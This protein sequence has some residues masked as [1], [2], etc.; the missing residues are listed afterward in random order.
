MKVLCRTLTFLLFIFA[1]CE[2]RIQ[3]VREFQPEG[4]GVNYQING[5]VDLGTKYLTGARWS[6]GGQPSCVLSVWNEKDQTV[7]NALYTADHISSSVGKEVAVF[8]SRLNSPARIFILIQAVDTAGQNQL[9]LAEYDSL[10]VRH[11]DR[12]VAASKEPVSGTMLPDFARGLIYVTGWI[13]ET[14]DVPTLYIFR[15]RPETRGTWTRKYRD[16]GLRFPDLRWCRTAGKDFIAAGILD[17]AGDVFYFRFDSLGG[18]KKLVRHESPETEAGV[19]VIAG[20]A[21]GGIALAAGSEG[22]GTGADYLILNYDEQ[23]HL[24]WAERVDG[25]GHGDDV[26]VQLATVGDGSIYI[27]GAGTAAGDQPAVMT[28]K[29][30]QDGARQWLR[31]F[32]GKHGR[33]V[34]PQWLHYSL[35]AKHYPG[36]EIGSNLLIAGTSGDQALVLRY[37]QNGLEA[38]LQFGR[39]RRVCTTAAVNDRY[40]VV[41]YEED[42]RAGTYLVRFGP[43]EIPGIK[44]W[45]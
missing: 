12:V 28:V 17:D 13:R 26:P 39:R 30:H 32:T 2:L 18:F 42:E 15:Y 19:P 14:D 16:P 31:I 34:Y 9:I 4:S 3:R 23:D 20:S 37:R 8:L 43:F 11:C 7:W 45:D 41:N 22:Q 36:Q 35:K 40:L 25:P 24:R 29:Y 21:E 33:A 38:S 44:R 5:F 10:G 1:G 27:T 6:A